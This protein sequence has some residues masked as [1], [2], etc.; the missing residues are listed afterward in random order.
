M[1]NRH[2]V[3]GS[4]KE[5]SKV[6][7]KFHMAIA[8]ACHNTIFIDLYRLISQFISNS[9]EQRGEFKGLNKEFDKLHLELFEAI[10]LKDSKKAEEVITKILTI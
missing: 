4:I 5:N 1:K 7:V 10:E 8:E 9:I 6:D 3:K 2:S